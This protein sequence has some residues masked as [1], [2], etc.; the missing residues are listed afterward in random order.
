MRGSYERG[1]DI[2]YESWA[3][4]TLGWPTVPMPRWRNQGNAAQRPHMLR[5]Y[6]GCRVF[7]Q[8]Q[9]TTRFGQER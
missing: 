3:P 2:R 9:T 1:S 6:Q 4:D 7:V 5:D 8:T